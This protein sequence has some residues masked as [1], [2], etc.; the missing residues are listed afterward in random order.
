PSSERSSLSLHDALPISTAAGA[1]A[2]GIK[3]GQELEGVLKSVAN[4][5]AAT[6]TDMAEMGGIF[7]KVASTGKAQNDVLSAVADRGL[8][9]YQALAD[10]L[11]VTADEVFKMA[12]AGEIGFDQFEQ[13]MK[14]AAGTVAEE[15]G[16]TTMGTLDNLGAAKIGRAH[17]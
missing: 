12:S 11:G 10:Q 17:V 13:A 16:G 4:S 14:S 1:V 9:I 6:G 7:N 8:P 15:L 3:P 2:A 5:A